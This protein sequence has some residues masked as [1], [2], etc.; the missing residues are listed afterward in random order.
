MNKINKNFKNI[1][2][3]LGAVS[4]FTMVIIFNKNC[5]VNKETQIEAFT[6]KNHDKN[7][8]ILWEI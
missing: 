4:I 3:I 6:I 2:I 7:L 1:W 5:N 8:Y